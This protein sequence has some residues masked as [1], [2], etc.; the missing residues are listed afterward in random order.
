MKTSL[1]WLNSY[2]ATL[3]DAHVPHEG[4]RAACGA[5]EELV[6]ALGGVDAAQTLAFEPVDV[7][8]FA[9]A[10]KVMLGGEE[11][12]RVGVLNEGLLDKFGLQS[13]V[14]LAEVDYEPFVEKYP[15]KRTVGNLP[16]FPGIERDLSIIVEEAITWQQVEQAIRDADPAMLEDLQFLTIFRGKQIGKGKKSLSLRML[17]RNPDVTLHH[18]EVD[19][20]VNAVV[21]KLKSAVGT[22][23]RG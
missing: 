10:A 17:F 5:I 22:E 1:A 20:Q 15:P 19:P 3:T 7:P 11:C 14:V 16:R 13:P 9:P 18:D 21:G 4:F 23:L 2:L 6:Q 8:K 12:G